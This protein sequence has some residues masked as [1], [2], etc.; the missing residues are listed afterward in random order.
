MSYEFFVARRYLTARRKQAFVSVI[1]IVS[2]LGICIGVMALVIAIALITGFQSD[3]QE[4]I[5]SSTSHIMVSDLTGEGISN[6]PEL[7]SKIEKV[8]GVEAAS[9]VAYS[10]VL[11]KGPLNTH[12]GMLKGVDFDREIRTSP[13]LQNLQGGQI[14][15][16]G[17]KHPGLLLGS[18]LAL[19]IGAG[20]GDVV[21]AFTSA[22]RLSPIG[23]IPRMKNFVVKG[24]FKTGLYEFDSSTALIPIEDAQAF[25]KMQNRISYFQVRVD[26]IFDASRIGDRIKEVLS[27][28]IYITT[29][30]DLNKSLFSALKLEKTIMFLTITLIVF[31]AALNIIAS[32]IL[33]VMEKTR[34]IGILIALGATSRNIRKIFFLQG[35]MIGMIGTAAGVVLGLFWCWM[36]NTFQIIK[37]PVDVYQIAYVPFYIKIVDLLLIIGVTL[38]ISFLSTLFPSRRAAKVDPVI[39]LKYE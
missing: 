32:L 25:F 39:A 11:L 5:L 19:D 30:M 1:T 21:T 31:V 37:V 14:P 10:M 23:P 9:P 18:R 33:M 29:W 26:H 3:V 24:I 27:P 7:L 16:R 34:D 12:A 35:A 13:W 6:Y 36:A 2:T 20:L 28:A 38:L 4:K 22:S 17:A 15:E 8:K